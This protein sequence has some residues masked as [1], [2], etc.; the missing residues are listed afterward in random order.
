MDEVFLK[1]Y[2]FQLMYHSGK[3]NVLAIALSRNIV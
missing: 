2:D 3:V 1:D